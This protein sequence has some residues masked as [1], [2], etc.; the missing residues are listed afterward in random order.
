MR[1]TLVIVNDRMQR[2]FR[3]WRTEPV[4]RNFDEGF[5]PQLTPAAGS[6]A[7]AESQAQAPAGGKETGGAAVEN[8][9]ASAVS[10]PADGPLLLPVGTYRLLVEKKFCAQ[11]TNQS[12]QIKSGTPRREYAKLICDKG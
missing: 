3:Y 2:G 9:R 10:L 12:L 4:G 6:G 7:P 8:R 5:E 11:Y 1:P